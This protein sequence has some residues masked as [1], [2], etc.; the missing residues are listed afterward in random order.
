MVDS[1]ST[2]LNQHQNQHQNYLSILKF[3]PPSLEFKEQLV[4]L[5]NIDF[6]FK[7]NCFFPDQLVNQTQ[8]LLVF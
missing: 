4:F 5:F 8:N 2:S 1:I 7:Y 6:F 3:E